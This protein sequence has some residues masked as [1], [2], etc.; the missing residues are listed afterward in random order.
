METLPQLIYIILTVIGATLVSSKHGKIK[1]ESKYNIWSFI[2]WRALMI[3]LLYE[4]GFF[5]N[6]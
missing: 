2:I 1:E 3:A 6:I 4:G 5:D